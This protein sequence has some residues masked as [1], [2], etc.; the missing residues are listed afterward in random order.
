MARKNNKS[1]T[2]GGNA[3]T[4]RPERVKSTN[5]KGNWYWRYVIH[6][7]G[8]LREAYGWFTSRANAKRA[9]KGDKEA[10]VSSDVNAVKKQ[11]LK[12]LNHKMFRK[13]PNGGRGVTPTELEK[14]KATVKHV[15]EYSDVDMKLDSLKVVEQVKSK[16]ATKSKGD[17]STAKK[18]GASNPF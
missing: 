5:G 10:R 11:V 18:S 14:A 15:P 2:K 16:K 7:N 13:A 6:V 8:E 9:C 17:G 3:S 1:T 4:G 12:S